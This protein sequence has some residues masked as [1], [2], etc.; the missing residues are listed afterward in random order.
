MRIETNTRSV[1]ENMGASGGIC[2]VPGSIHGQRMLT[3]WL[4]STETRTIHRPHVMNQ[5]G[6]CNIHLALEQ[7]CK[8]GPAAEP[9]RR[10]ATRVAQSAAECAITL[11]ARS[12]GCVLVLCVWA[13]V[14][15]GDAQKTI[16][17]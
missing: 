12:L 3:V 17:V 13:R 6:K 14:L 4:A 15:C 1:R 9:T 16:R 5:L 8:A 7:V 11:A 2:G 10:A